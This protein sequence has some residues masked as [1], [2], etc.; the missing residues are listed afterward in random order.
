[1]VK[2][3]FQHIRPAELRGTHAIGDVRYQVYKGGLIDVSEAHA[4]QLRHSKAWKLVARSQDA[5]DIND[6][7]EEAKAEALAKAKAKAEA[8]A[9]AKAKALAEAEALA[10]WNA[11]EAKREAEAEALAKAKAKDKADNK[12]GK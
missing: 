1:M 12:K 11:E 6:G 9:E 2:Y 7:S 8:E 10:L 3:R 5:P 4:R